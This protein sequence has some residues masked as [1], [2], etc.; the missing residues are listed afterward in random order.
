MQ[1]EVTG[2][3]RTTGQDRSIIV[4]ADTD[5]SARRLANRQGLLVADAR[6]LGNSGQ[7]YQCS[8]CGGRFQPEEG[9]DCAGEFVCRSCYGVGVPQPVSNAAS[10][11]KKKRKSPLIPVVVCVLVLTGIAGAV[12]VIATRQNG[13]SASSLTAG[14][15]AVPGTTPD[16]GVLLSNF[17]AF[18]HALSPAMKQDEERNLR[19]GNEAIKPDERDRSQA[20][21]AEAK[22]TVD[23]LSTDLKKSDSLVFPVVGVAVVRV[24]VDASFGFFERTYTITMGQSQGKWKVS[25]ATRRVRHLNDTSENAEQDV[26]RTIQEAV[27]RIQQ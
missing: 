6:P 22:V 5:D 20:T 14:T 8:R 18:L 13:R 11:Q 16:A 7:Q 15:L 27:D 23:V 19:R 1:W 17:N 25:K 3:D 2:A 21:D 10:R 9:Y 4:E 24:D 26:T 12:Y